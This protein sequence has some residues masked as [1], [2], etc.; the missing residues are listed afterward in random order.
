MGYTGEDDA[1]E[2][3]KTERTDSLVQEEAPPS[4]LSEDQQ[5]TSDG[6]GAL[7]EEDES[8]EL[9]KVAKRLVASAVA[10]AVQTVIMEGRMVCVKPSKTCPIS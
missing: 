3:G 10:K 1:P 8:P 9:I 4:D 2:V 7:P 5:D 6:P